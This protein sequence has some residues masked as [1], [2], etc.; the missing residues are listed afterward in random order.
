MHRFGVVAVSCAAALAAYPG[1][2]HA[3]GFT[4]TGS[5]QAYTVPGGVTQVTISAIGA[6]G[7]MPPAGSGLSGGR[8]AQVA[9]VVAVTPGQVLYVHVGGTGEQPGGGY[10]GGGAG[11]VTQQG[12]MAWGGGGASDVRT[13]AEM[14]GAGSLESRVIVAAGG[15]GS[16]GIAAGG[17]DAG[18]PGGCCGAA[19]TGPDTAQP[20][21]QTAGGAGGCGGAVCGAAG[22]L[23]RGGA[24]SASGMD[25]DQRAGGGGGAGLYGGGG[26]PGSLLNTG[27]GAGGSSKVP[28]NGS[29]T[30]TQAAARVDIDPYTPPPL[31]TATPVPTPTA[32]P[33][34]PK[35]MATT[36]VF[37]AVS[38]KRSTRF[39]KV[40]LR[41]IPA[42][43][44][45]TARCVTCKNGGTFTTSPTRAEVGLKR[46]Q[47]VFPVGTRLE[48]VISN[49]AYITQIH[50]LAVRRNRPPRLT[51]L[52]RPV[53][54]SRP[55]RCPVSRMLRR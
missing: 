22:V 21:T 11:G 36:L 4:F 25:A 24:G 9:G 17:G 32:T 7:G 14:A 43:S 2:A 5:E 49:P 42:G 55:T 12:G 10:N 52:C 48:V 46:F 8:G 29:I 26:G 15:G 47:H 3:T 34:P 40:R 53:G 41:N 38:K 51:T 44:T 16:A 19:G 20:G 39:T 50:T 27:G 35:A 13:V 37:T 23:G 33:A 28:S 31:P 1:V 30:L 6:A 18:A 54:S 45:V